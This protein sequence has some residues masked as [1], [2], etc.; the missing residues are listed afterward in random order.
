MGPEPFWES[1]EE[2]SI[3]KVPNHTFTTPDRTE[4]P[5]ERRRQER[6]VTCEPGKGKDSFIKKNRTEYTLGDLRKDTDEIQKEDY[7]GL[8]REERGMCTHT[9]VRIIRSYILLFVRADRGNQ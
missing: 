4:G 6:R 8:R 9:E 1:T 5:E 7:E 2:T 3:G